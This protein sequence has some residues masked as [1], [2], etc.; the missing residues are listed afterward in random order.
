LA[1][2]R[3]LEGSTPLDFLFRHRINV[4]Q[5]ASMRL[6]DVLSKLGVTLDPARAEGLNLH[7]RLR[8]DDEVAGLHLRRCVAVVTDG[9][10]ADHSLSLSREAL[11]ELLSGAVS[12]SELLERPGVA[13]EGARSAIATLLSTFELEGLRP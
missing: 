5:L 11:G 9:V 3:H 12:V 8:V 4:R 2:A 13:E 1:R 7:V 6:V 10:G